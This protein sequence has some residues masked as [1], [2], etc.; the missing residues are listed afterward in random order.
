M[1][2]SGL[3]GQADMGSNKTDKVINQLVASWSVS[4]KGHRPR[5]KS[6]ST[7]GLLNTPHFL[8]FC[9]AELGSWRYFSTCRGMKFPCV[10]R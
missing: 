4:R 2:I 6:L 1:R 7:K 9:L 10:K 5:S 8:A 3:L